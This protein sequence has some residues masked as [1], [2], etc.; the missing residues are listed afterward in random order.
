[1]T[2]IDFKALMA[3]ERRRL[4]KEALG[5]Q[6]P[7]TAVLEP[8]AVQQQQQGKEISYHLTPR[9]E[10]PTLDEKSAAHRVECG[11]SGVWH[12]PEWLSESEE[13]HLMQCIDS[14][15]LAAWTPLRGRRLQS[16]GGH[17]RPPPEMMTHE[18]L[19][20]WVQSICDALIAAGAFSPDEPPNHVLLNEYAPGQGI[21]AHKDGPLYMPRVAI[22]SL[23]SH[24][25]FR[26]VEDSVGREPVASLLLPRRG[27]LVFS[28]DAYEQHLHTVTADEA[29]DLSRPG[30]VRLDVAESCSMGSGARDSERAS[31]PSSGSALLPRTRRLSL[32][33]RRVLHERY[34]VADIKP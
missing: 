16:L 12:V 13:R 4:R 10:R 1:M 2:S 31:G 26:F 25:T 6:Q 19:A 29:D 5:I 11:T 17:P 23:G 32:T 34:G 27:L 22:V 18:P 8:A 33:V 7:A 30:L 24:S 3:E 28:G 9:A 21:D 14:M 15:P 20:P